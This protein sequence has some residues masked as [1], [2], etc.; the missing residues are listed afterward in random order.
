MWNSIAPPSLFYQFLSPISVIP[1]HLSMGEAINA[2]LNTVTTSSSLVGAKTSPPCAVIER[3]G[4]LIGKL[5]LASILR[6]LNQSIPLDRLRVTY[7][8][9]PLL[10]VV[11]LPDP[12][13]PWQLFSLWNAGQEA[14]IIIVDEQRR[15]L[16]QLTAASVC[17]SLFPLSFWET[18]PVQSAPL[19]QLWQRSGSET[20]WDAIEFMKQHQISV[21]SVALEDG[22]H[23]WLED[24]NILKLIQSGIDLKNLLLDRIAY[25]SAATI[26]PRDSLSNAYERLETRR[27]RGIPVVTPEA[28]VSGWLERSH[29]LQ[30]LTPQVVAQFLSQSPTIGVQDIWLSQ[31]GDHH[32]LNDRSGYHLV[33]NAPMSAKALDASDRA[34]AVNRG[35]AVDRAGVELLNSVDSLEAGVSLS[36]SLLSPSPHALTHSHSLADP[37]SPDPSPPP[38]SEFILPSTLQASPELD[39]VVRKNELFLHINHQIHESLNL[40]HTLTAITREICH[41]LATDRVVIYQFHVNWSGTIVAESL[42]AGCQSLLGKEIKDEYFAEHLIEPYRNGRIQVTDNIYLSNLTG[43]HINLLAQIEV[44]ALIVVPIVMGNKLWGLLSAQSCHQVRHWLPEEITILQELS[45]EIA[46]AIRNSI[47][48]Q[49]AQEKINSYQREQSILDRYALQQSVV[50]TL[51]HAAIQAPDFAGLCQQAVELISEVCQVELAAVL[52]LLPNQAAL[53]LQAGVGW[54][55][56]W[57][58]QAQTQAV[59]NEICGYTLNAN[60]PVCFQ[61]LL[62]ETRF[63]GGPMFHNQNIV[64]G[65]ST[66]IQGKGCIYG[67]L[68]VFST[69]KHQFEPDDLDFLQAVANTLSMALSRFQT[70]QQLSQFFDLS[71]EIFCILNLERSILK[72]NQHF[73]DSLG[74]RLEDILN[75]D[76]LKW[77]HP[78]DQTETE[79]AFYNLNSGFSIQNLQ[80]RYQP[81]T[82]NYIWLEW[83]A[84][85]SQDNLIYAVARNITEQKKWQQALQQSHKSLSDFKYALDQSSIVSISDPQGIITYVN[86]NFCEISGYSKT[87]LIGQNH[88]IV[89]AHYHPHATFED[90]WNT[91]NQGKVWR[92]EVKNRAKN[93]EYFWCD[94]TIV[95]FIDQEGKPIQHVA[96]RKDITSRKQAEYALSILAKTAGAGEDFFQVLVESLATTL[97][98]PVVYISVENREKQHEFPV[99]AMVSPS[100]EPFPLDP[101]SK[102]ATAEDWFESDRL[103]AN[104]VLVRKWNCSH[105]VRLHLR[106]STGKICGYLGLASSKSL[107]LSAFHQEILQVFASRAA[108]ELERRAIDLELQEL[109]ADLERRVE[110]RTLELQEAKELAEAANSA[111]SEFLARMSHEIRTPMNAILGM[112][113]L[114]LQTPLNEKQQ[115]YLTK[116]QKAGNSLLSIINE[117]LDFSKI[118]GNH[119]K[120]EIIDFD[121]G[122]LLDEIL[123]LLEI[124]A[125]R[126]GLTLTLKTG[127]LLSRYYRGDPTRLRQILLNLV[128]NAL[129]FTAEGSVEIFVEERSFDPNSGQCELYF[130]VKDTGIGILPEHQSSVFQAFQQADGSISRHYGGTGLG[131]AICKRLTE[132]MGGQIW[133]ETEPGVGSNF[134]FTIVLERCDMALVH[135]STSDN[136]SP[137]NDRTPMNP[138]QT[139]SSLEG[140]HILLVEEDDI[141]QQLGMELLQQKNVIVD[142]VDTG[143]AAL[144]A[145]QRQTYDLI[146]LDLHI[147]DMDPWELCQQLRSLSPVP[148]IGMS[149]NALDKDRAEQKQNLGMNSHLLKPLNPVEFYQTLARWLNP[150]TRHQDPHLEPVPFLKALTPLGHLLPT[151]PF[152][153]TDCHRIQGL[154]TELIILVESD[155][156]AAQEKQE[157][158]ANYLNSSV[159][160]VNYQKIKTAMETFDMDRV[161]TELQSLK[162]QVDGYCDPYSSAEA[163]P[164]RET[165]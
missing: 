149:T 36:H 147:P 25:P 123:G 88:R 17:K 6:G 99:L 22:T 118:E 158:L 35:D 44:K 115:D 117:I 63:R 95:P 51:S 106:S 133:F 45:Q 125:N 65:M 43:C 27:L 56:E 14:T 108:T 31:D 111:K 89:N 7:E 47:L 136:N 144:K 102:I 87:E 21:L 141:N 79:I 52:G 112:I 156:V 58:G 9:E 154:L 130:Q 104:H 94:T 73:I 110:N 34:D 85:S 92:S 153:P 83:T 119:L 77:V 71:H 131:L 146:L 24:W 42:E 38:S 5:T 134:Q 19:A 145:M 129:K 74:Y 67:I 107:K 57:L 37:P 4:E 80:N 93:G 3:K 150:Q 41:F 160:Q 8:M 2:I 101:L 114:C 148:I 86:D 53:E 11:P 155:V 97:D 78:Q 60:A 12:C 1:D 16:G 121:L 33:L 70:E 139:L 165:N 91:I 162:H 72:V 40:N 128:G 124:K 127:D 81:K 84:V 15:C 39:N 68:G 120:L 135:A 138:L 103:S 69:R 20:A 109:T 142:C 157:E 105:C 90:L 126:Q 29:L 96:I 76:L 54:P 32:P 55:Q 49:V 23:E 122:D 50:A 137:Q 59:A 48:Y 143:Y 75:Q 18:H 161:M 13:S 116:V 26:F 151:E 46:F 62:V 152:A 30:G 140:S 82:G 64:S 159:L 100:L 163:C 113:Y 28:Q 66:T 10:W 164:P 61:D 132:L 98:I